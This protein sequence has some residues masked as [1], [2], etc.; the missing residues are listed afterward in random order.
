MKLQYIDFQGYSYDE[1]D[2]GLSHRINTDGV[3]NRPI[4]HYPDTYSWLSIRIVRI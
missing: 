4:I 1:G 3:K 2:I